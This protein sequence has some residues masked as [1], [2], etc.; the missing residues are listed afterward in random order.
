M[1]GS[2]LSIERF[3]KG[4]SQRSKS[5][6][7]SKK[8]VIVHKALRRREYEKVKKREESTAGGNGNASVGTSFYDQFFSDLKN[9]TIS[10]DA[11]EVDTHRDKKWL[12]KEDKKQA[13]K[14]DPLFKAK[15]KALVGKLEKQRNHEEWQKRKAAAEKKVTQ[16]KKRHVKLSQRTA[17]GQPV[18]KNYI[19]DILTRLEAE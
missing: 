7:K 15:K 2:G 3:I 17:T 14:P 9:S 13:V 18:V 19:N 12:Q 8:K 16:R 5:D 4:K 6:A 1:R 10:E 11:E